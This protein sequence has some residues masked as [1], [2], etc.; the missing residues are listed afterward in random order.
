[1][2]EL[3]LLLEISG[4]TGLFGERDFTTVLLSEKFKVSQQTISNVLRTLE[5]DKLIVRTP[6]NK[7][8]RISISGEGQAYLLGYKKRLD[9]IFK[10]QCEIVGAVFSGLG[11]GK[12]YVSQSGYKRQ[13]ERIL[14]IKAYDGTLNL[15]VKIDDAR[16]FFLGKKP[17]LIDG[18]KTSSRSFGELLAYRIKINNVL[19]FIVVP[20]RT[21]HKE[22]TIEIISEFY[23]RDELRLEDGDKVIITGD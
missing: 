22:D 12:F 13:F 3:D 18:F 2:E 9:N 15:K 19:G 14:N 10:P 11:E 20:A 17:I 4:K 16:K 5:E 23:L 1:M 8:I 21:H 6:F 7:G